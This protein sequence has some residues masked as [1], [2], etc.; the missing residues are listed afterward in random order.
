M[1]Q[2][3]IVNE[4]GTLEGSECKI[5]ASS[6]DEKFENYPVP[7]GYKKILLTIEEYDALSLDFD[8]EKLI[9]NSVVDLNAGEEEYKV[10]K[11]TEEAKQAVLDKRPEWYRDTLE[12]DGKIKREQKDGTL[13]EVNPDNTLTP[14]IKEEERK[15][16]IRK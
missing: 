9:H 1:I 6:N 4:N 14:W 8:Y 12:S 5:C 7:D 11:M 16:I 10:R 15:E 3:A 2:F 13:W